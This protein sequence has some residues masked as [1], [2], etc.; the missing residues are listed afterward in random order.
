MSNEPNQPTGDSDK[1]F[2]AELQ[3]ELREMGRQLEAAFRATLESDR[4]KR[5]QS[6][7]AAGVRELSSQVKSA[8]ENIQKDPRVQEAEERGRQAVAQARDSK[9]AQE[10]QELLITGIGQ[11]N[12]QLRK[13]VERLES[14]RAAAPTPTQHVKV[15][16]EPTTGETTKLDE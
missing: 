2:V 1:D 16:H 3:T 8:V 11:L 7:L 12:T 14:E 10:V 9:A 15:D 6:D 4:T 5:L 13:F